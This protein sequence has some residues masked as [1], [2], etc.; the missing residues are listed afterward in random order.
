MIKAPPSSAEKTTPLAVSSGADKLHIL[1][2][3][4]QVGFPSCGGIFMNNAFA[5]RFVKDADRGEQLALSGSLIPLFYSGS[6]FLQLSF[7]RGFRR[8]ISHSSGLGNDDPFFR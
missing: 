7:H 1:K 3:A 5:G 2:I 6:K 8:H 4:V